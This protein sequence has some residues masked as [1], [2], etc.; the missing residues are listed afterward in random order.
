M[1]KLLFCS[2][3]ADGAPRN[4]EEFL[5]GLSRDAAVP[6]GSPVSVAGLLKLLSS[7][8]QQDAVNILPWQ[9]AAM[10]APLQHQDFFQ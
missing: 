7:C 1:D 3:A 8:R 4:T 2:M 6:W 9:P 10:L 5:C